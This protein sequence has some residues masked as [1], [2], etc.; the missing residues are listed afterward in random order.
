MAGMGIFVDYS[1]AWEGQHSFCYKQCKPCMTLMLADIEASADF[2]RE[3]TN[4]D[5]V[6]KRVILHGL[7]EQIRDKLDRL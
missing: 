5:A 4:D 7:R 6:M 3:S 2:F 1:K